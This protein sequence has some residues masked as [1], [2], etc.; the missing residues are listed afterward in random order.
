[1]S[2][3]KDEYAHLGVPFS[4]RGKLLD[5]HLTIWKLLWTQTPASYHSDFL[6]FEDLYM[7]P[8]PHRPGGP[9]LWFGGQTL[10]EPIARR[11]VEHGCGFHPLGAPAP[12]ELDMIRQRMTAAGRN[13]DDLEKIG[14]IR[15]VFPDDDSPSS[16]DDGLASI[17]SQIADGYTTFCVKPNQF[18]DDARDFEPFMRDLV[19]AFADMSV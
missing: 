2:W 9:L 13:F 17:P 11:L 6:S 10:S 1:V 14:G 12:A 4:Q 3:H 16:L 15:A 7:E 19:A 8:K 18:I 5:E